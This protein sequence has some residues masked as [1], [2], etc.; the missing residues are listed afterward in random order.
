[1]VKRD[2]SL[3][4]RKDAQET[5]V[6]PVLRFTPARK[7]ETRTASKAKWVRRPSWVG[8]VVSLGVGGNCDL[9]KVCLP[10]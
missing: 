6:R 1:L 3:E 5:Y 9:G 8:G 4:K 2:S 10:P 7:A